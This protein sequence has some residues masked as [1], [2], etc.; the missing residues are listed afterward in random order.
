MRLKGQLLVA[1]GVAIIR[2][3]DSIVVINK[4]EE[5]STRVAVLV[6]V[7]VYYKHRQLEQL[8]TRSC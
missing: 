6:F 2:V 1:G 3:I 7:E 4:T 8:I 5:R